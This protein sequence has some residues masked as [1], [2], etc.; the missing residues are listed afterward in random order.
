MKW[1]AILT[2]VPSY[3]NI[4]FCV[5]VRAFYPILL[6]LRF[7]ASSAYIFIPEGCRTL[8]PGLYSLSRFTWYA[9]RCWRVFTLPVTTVLAVSAFT[10]FARFL[11]I[12]YLMSGRYSPPLGVTGSPVAP[13]IYA[14]S[15]E[16]VEVPESL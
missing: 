3:C 2:R 7:R 6:A 12:S 14:I 16:V 5:T 13:S 1:P 15:G 11:I 8:V 10:V 4:R 9:L